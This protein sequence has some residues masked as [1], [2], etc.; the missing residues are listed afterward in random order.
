MNT[1]F[2][3]L[4][5]TDKIGIFYWQDF[6]TFTAIRSMDLSSS[7][8]KLCALSYLCIEYLRKIEI[9]TSVNR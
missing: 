2:P 4:H 6:V 9:D 1:Y 3:E 7:N 5:N 8:P